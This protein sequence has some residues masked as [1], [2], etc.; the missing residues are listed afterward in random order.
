MGKELTVLVIDGGARGHTVSCAYER[1]SDVKK[2]IVAPGNDFVAYNRSKEVIVDKNC[3]LNDASTILDVAKKHKPDLV[4]VCQDDALAAGTVDILRTEGFKTFG[5]TKE[6]SRLEWDK[7]WARELMQKNKIPIPMFR[8]FSSEKYA[9]S[10]ANAIYRS[11]PNR[12]IFVKANGLCAGKGVIKAES[13]DEAIEAVSRMKDFGEAGKSFLIEDG[14]VGEE[15]SYY[16]ISDGNTYKVFK[17]AQDNKRINNFDMG[18]NTGG[19]GAAAPAMITDDIDADIRKNLIDKVINGMKSEG[20]PFSGILFVGGMVTDAGPMNIEYNARWG[21]PECQAV[22]PALETDYVELILAC[23]DG[24]LKDIEVKQDSKTRVCVVG[25][26]RGY[27]GDYSDVK[28]KRIFGLEDALKVQGVQ[29]FGAGI[30]MADGNF[31]ANG[32]R[33]FSVV[34]EGDTIVE[35]KQ[36]AYEAIACIN[37]EGNNLHYRTDIGWRDVERF[38]KKN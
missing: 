10:Y 31:Y 27:P 22:L 29:I 20:Y 14:L 5:P 3:V 8:Y 33:L 1:S 23:I 16:A 30:A 9:K 4:E 15:F 32:G 17:S 2:I 26:S 38:L 36:R 28:G 37:I 24:K 35:A 18:P 19:M 11:K 6:E 13:L 21:D 34:G 12:L 7:K 25:A